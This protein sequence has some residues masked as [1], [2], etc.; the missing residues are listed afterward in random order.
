MVP[1]SQNYT[2]GM[3]YFPEGY[4]VTHQTSNCCFS[5]S[6][7]LQAGPRQAGM[8]VRA[9]PAPRSPCRRGCRDGAPSGHVCP[10]RQQHVSPTHGQ[11]LLPAPALPGLLDL[12]EGEAGEGE[13]DW[14]QTAQKQPQPGPRGKNKPEKKHLKG[15]NGAWRNLGARAAATGEDTFCIPL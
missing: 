15:P 5:P 13:A 2:A 6:N 11:G 14:H 7:P 10:P 4:G 9:G 12:R 1:Q 8:Q 3:N